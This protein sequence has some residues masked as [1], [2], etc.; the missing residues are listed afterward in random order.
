MTD[1]IKSSEESNPILPLRNTVLF[2]QQI[3]PIYIG[4]DQSLKLIDDLPENGD[5]KIIVVAQR[6]G[7]IENPKSEDLFE[8]GTLALVMRV[9]NMPDKQK[10]AI[11]QGIARIKITKYYQSTPYFI[12]TGIRFDD[13]EDHSVELEAMMTNLHSIYQKLVDVAPYLSNEQY[14]QV[15]SITHPGKY[16][17]RAV[18]VMNIS[19]EEKQKIL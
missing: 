6:D 7:S 16:A 1:L 14:K 8:W 13:P 4:R 10:S 12:G 9:F 15:T 3:I 11:V 18:S 5:K 2:P 19:T 17:D